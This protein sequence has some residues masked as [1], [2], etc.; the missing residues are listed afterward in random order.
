MT[1]VMETEDVSGPRE[2]INAMSVTS[3]SGFMGPATD[4]S[5][6][7]DL[8]DKLYINAGSTAPSPQRVRPGQRWDTPGNSLGPPCLNQ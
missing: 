5:M 4:V 3:P 6:L 1:H 8:I 7:Q 2:D